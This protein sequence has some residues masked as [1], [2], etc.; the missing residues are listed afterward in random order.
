MEK[1]IDNII[2]KCGDKTYLFATKKY[3]AQSRN[4]TKYILK[5]KTAF[6]S[7]LSA[8]LIFTDK[9]K[10]I[11]E[12]MYDLIKQLFEHWDEESV[13][14]GLKPK[15]YKNIHEAELDTNEEYGELIQ[16]PI[17]NGNKI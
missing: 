13:R 10:L 8:D 2:V 1:P 16:K 14:L 12:Q 4:W 9:E 5:K 15:K 11:L 6:L 7:W 3:L 17:K